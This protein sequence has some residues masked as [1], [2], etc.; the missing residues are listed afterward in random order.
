MFYAQD[1][2]NSSAWSGDNILLSSAPLNSDSP[3]MTVDEVNIKHRQPVKAGL[4]AQFKLTDRL[5]LESGM[6]YTYLSSDFTCGD[7]TNG[8]KTRQKLH[9]VGI[10]VRLTCGLWQNKSLNVYA[11][12]GAAVEIG[13]GG[14][15]R[16][17]RVTESR[18][19]QGSEES[20][21]EKRPQYSVNASAGL[22]YDFNDHVGVYV[23]PGVSY[24]IKNG[25]SVQNF[26]KDKPLNFSLSL[27]LRF[28]VK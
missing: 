4:S 25:S 9:Y 1:V 12:A 15:S 18:V 27:G 28:T 19:E 8:S 7:E 3:K 17:D 11:G 6:Y 2:Q 23:E 22:Q 16:T 14:S 24:Y 5:G 13:V 26:Y 20:M 21:R 10:P